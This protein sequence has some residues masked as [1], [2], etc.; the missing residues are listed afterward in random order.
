M[1]EL[2]YGQ[3]GNERSECWELDSA[4]LLI[5][6]IVSK[7]PKL[8]YAPRIADYTFSTLLKTNQH[9]TYKYGKIAIK[10]PTYDEPAYDEIVGLVEFYSHNLNLTPE[11]YLLGIEAYQSVIDN[12]LYP[13]IFNIPKKNNKIAEWYWRLSDKS[14]AIETQ[15][16]AI[17]AMKIY[18]YTFQRKM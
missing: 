7:E 17:G 5:D 4:L 10:T 6:K 2:T 13:K 16:K 9:R 14:R 12:F 15:R 18:I 11:I 8:K 1:Y 3:N